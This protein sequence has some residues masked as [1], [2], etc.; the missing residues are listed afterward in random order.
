MVVVD[1]VT[2]KR[3]DYVILCFPLS[4]EVY[5]YSYVHLFMLIVD[6]EKLI[7]SKLVLCTVKSENISQC[8]SQVFKILFKLVYKVFQLECSKG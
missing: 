4:M 1:T 3:S 7:L 8:I 5:V 6:N 2:E